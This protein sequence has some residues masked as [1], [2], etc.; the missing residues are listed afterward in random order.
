[1][2]LWV[3]REAMEKAEK[4]NMT[5]F[6]ADLSRIFERKKDRKLL[7]AESK[8]KGVNDDI[9]SGFDMIPRKCQFQSIFEISIEISLLRRL[10]FNLKKN[11][12]FEFSLKT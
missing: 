7:I 11:E 6:H 9:L 3:Q 10:L 4:F 8:V 1:L 12:N 2:L 5:R